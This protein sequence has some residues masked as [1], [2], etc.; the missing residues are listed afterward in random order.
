MEENTQ[1]RIQSELEKVHAKHGIL[2]A[3]DVVKFA[4]NPKTALHKQFVWDDTEAARRYR[5]VQAREIIRVSV[6][7]EPLVSRP[8]QAWVSLCDDRE[9]PGGG[10]RPLCEVMSDD[11]LRAKL[12][13]QALS[14]LRRLQ[15]K[16]A[17]LKELAPVFAALEEAVA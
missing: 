12:L 11:E 5:L 15:K 10:Y 13:S 3:E 16:Y 6:R 8:I 14:E 7:V 2:R 1:A 9:A 17:D 4:R